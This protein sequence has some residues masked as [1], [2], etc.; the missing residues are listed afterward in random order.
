MTA[1]GRASSVDAVSVDGYESAITK[2]WEQGRRPLE[3]ALAPLKKDLWEIQPD[4]MVRSSNLVVAIIEMGGS[5]GSIGQQRFLVGA[6]RAFARN[7]KMMVAST[8]EGMELEIIRI[9][10]HVTS[11]M[12]MYRAWVRED[13]AEASIR[14]RYPK[15]GTLRNKCS[16]SHL[17]IIQ[18]VVA[19]MKLDPVAQDG[20]E[21]KAVVP[22]A[23]VPEVPVL[24]AAPAAFAFPT[25]FG[26]FMSA[27]HGDDD[28]EYYPSRDSSIVRSISPTAPRSFSMRSISP[29]ASEAPP[30]TPSGTA[31][32]LALTTP[33]PAI[34][35]FSSEPSGSFTSPV[36]GGNH[37]V[38]SQ[39]VGGTRLTLFYI[40]R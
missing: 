10:Q 32:K 3:V 11:I 34:T 24:Q 6:R 5:N 25:C 21:T 39:S 22:V 33:S 18:Q 7:P 26:R 15:T 27:R 4:D 1:V 2:A 16:S 38:G 14:R 8:P 40:R 19:K 35:I 12:G 30:R 20:A 31:S 37:S 13:A 23:D 28:T 36:G 29:A 17:L 9:R